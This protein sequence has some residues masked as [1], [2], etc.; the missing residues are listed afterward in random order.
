TDAGV[1]ILCG[2][3][4]YAFGR[5]TKMPAGATLGPLL[6]SAAAHLAGL[7]EGAPPQTVIFIVQ[8]VLGSYIGARFVDMEWSEFRSALGHGIIWSLGLIVIATLAAIVCAWETGF[9]LPQLL[10]AFAPGGLAEMGLLT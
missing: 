3:A 10:L 9:G 7:T 6:V 2:V 5:L 1:L 8:I 4:G